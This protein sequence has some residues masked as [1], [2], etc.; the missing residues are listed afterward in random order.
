MREFSIRNFA[1]GTIDSIEDFSIPEEAA[2]SSLNWLTLGDKIELTGGYDTIGTENSGAGAITGLEIAEKVDGTLLPIRTHGQKVE[3]Y[4]SDWNESGTNVLG[5]DADGEDV[6]ISLYTSLAGYQAWLSSANSGY[7]KMMLANPDDIKD[8]YNGAKNFKGYI[9]AQNVRMHLWGRSTNKHYLYGSYKDLQNSTTY[10]TVS[11]ESIGSSGSTNYTG[12]L[13]FPGVDSG[14]TNFT[15]ATTDICTAVGH[16][17]ISGDIVQ[18]ATSGTLP[19]GLSASTDYW[20]EKIDDDTFYLFPSAEYEIRVDITGT[21]SGTHTFSTSGV[22]RTC[23]NVVFNDGTQYVQ[24][25][26]NGNLIGDVDAG[27]NNT[28]NY[29]TGEYD[30]TFASTTTGAVVSDYQWEDS[31]KQGVADYTFTSPT[32]TAAQGFFLAQPTGGDI[33]N[34]LFYKQ[35]AYMPHSRNTWL[36]N[37]SIDDLDVTNEVFREDTGMPHWRAAVATGEGIY[38]ID[39]SNPS[40]PR[41]KLLTL[42]TANTEVVPVAISFNVNL[43]GY[44]F[45]DSVAFRWGEYVLFSCK[46][47]NS[48]NNNRTFAYNTKWKSFDMTNYFAKCFGDYNGALWVG[49]SASN[50]VYQAFTGF[51]ANGALIDNYWE[52]KLSK[53]QVD[54]LKKFKRLSLRG[55]IGSDQS[56][57]VSLAYDG[58]SFSEVGTIDGDGDYV[59]TAAATTIGSPQVGSA[60]VAGGGT[61]ITA[62]DYIREFRIRSD[63][64]DEVKVRIE[65]TSVGYASVSEI[66][67]YDI[68]TYTQKNLR[69]F[70]TTS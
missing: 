3:Y 43:S 36:F 34:M 67:F 7:Y 20:V 42:D 32:R 25:D 9:K 4:T 30:V 53:L 58:G 31:T 69:R 51:S 65:A 13:N 16:G 19:T 40:E 23:F 55:Q 27:G 22:N 57:K 24:D 14:T 38:Y 8:L 61:G 1:K 5:A 29:A 15:A 21:G 6:S 70:R 44:D 11:D 59:S 17:L 28:I 37:I 46:T 18:V 48:D 26:K 35:N 39:N 52:G 50:N 56:L 10:T 66:N 64:F 54:Q 33:Q 60:E 63:R 49:D 2:S 62:Y 41:F 12:T 45:S 68:K 47:S